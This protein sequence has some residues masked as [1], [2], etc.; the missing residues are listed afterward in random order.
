MLL[1]QVPT[2][3]TSIVTPRCFNMIDITV[4]DL[5]GADLDAFMTGVGYTFVE[6]DPAVTPPPVLLQSADASF[7]QLE[8]SNA[9]AL[10]VTAWVGAT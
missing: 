3:D 4:D 10:V 9:G 6:V 7:F 1:S 5:F 2:V 8:V